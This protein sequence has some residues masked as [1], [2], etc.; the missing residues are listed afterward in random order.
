M[1]RFDV[2]NIPYTEMK[3]THSDDKNF[4]QSLYFIEFTYY[5]YKS[6]CASFLSVVNLMMLHELI[7]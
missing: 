1:I 2:M 6:L 5:Y 3:H 4:A 7:F